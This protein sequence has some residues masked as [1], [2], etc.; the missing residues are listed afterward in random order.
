MRLV[1]VKSRS[2]NSLCKMNVKMSDHKDKEIKHKIELNRY[3][4]NKFQSYDFE[5]KRLNCKFEILNI[6]IENHKNDCEEIEYEFIKLEKSNVKR[7]QAIDE[8][9]V[10]TSKEQ[11][12]TQVKKN[13][14][15]IDNKTIKI[16][17][18]KTSQLEEAQKQLE[19]NILLKTQF[20]EVLKERDLFMRKF[21]DLNIK[22]DYL[23]RKIS[24]IEKNLSNNT[25]ES[26]D[27]VMNNSTQKHDSNANLVVLSEVA[28]AL[29]KYDQ[30]NAVKIKNE[31]KGILISFFSALNISVLKVFIFSENAKM[32]IDSSQ[33]LFKCRLCPCITDN[34]E[35][36]KQHKRQHYSSSTSQAKCRYCNFNSTVLE[37]NSHE[38]LHAKR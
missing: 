19:N 27:S 8:L 20:D 7:D 2:E 24:N 14:L 18:E 16:G 12:M 26:I 22:Y 11:N 3:F 17:N 32:L 34:R 10:K 30:Q 21:D 38:K 37:M 23:L 15:E 29:F 36:L 31:S 33:S 5:L 35:L 9:M 1:I 6:S 13:D 25:L 4:E 28:N